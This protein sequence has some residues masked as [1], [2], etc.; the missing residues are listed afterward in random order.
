MGDPYRKQ[1]VKNAQKRREIATREASEPRL[2]VSTAFRDMK[3]ALIPD[4]GT[5]YAS[6]ERLAI[7]ADESSIKVVRHGYE[8][9]GHI[10]GE[11]A[12][13]LRE[14][15]AADGGT[16]VIEVQITDV[17]EISGVAYAEVIQRQ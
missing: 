17:A 11:V 12:S 2:P 3:L 7:M 14:L 9:V 6:G 4:E 13:K 16:N 10:D 1:Q 5:Q 8:H 15:F